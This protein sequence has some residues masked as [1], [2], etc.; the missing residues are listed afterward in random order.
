MPPPPDRPPTTA[1]HALKRLGRIGL[2]LL[3]PP[4]CL[5]CGGFDVQR[6]GLACSAC[7]PGIAFAT[8]AA[9]PCC[10][11]PLPAHAAPGERC[12]PCLKSPPAFCETAAALRYEGAVRGLIARFKHGDG[13]WAAPWLADWMLPSAAPLLAASDILVPVPVHRWRLLR[14]RYNQAALLAGAL[15]GKSGLP[16]VPDALLRRRATRSQG[17]LTRRERQ[18]NVAHA[19]VIH[20]GRK[21]A[22][23]GKR[24]LLVDDVMTTGATLRGCA[25]V[26]A[27]AG[28]AEIR[29]AILART[30]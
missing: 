3:L 25:T 12:G 22:V 23:A 21:A 29:V 16:H 11:L 14:R 5:L 17:R 9:C 24:V 4:R 19:F 15:A 28:V 2:D 6:Q 30:P 27:A 7:W 10:A 26:L 13:S 1:P 8:G 18:G 20:P